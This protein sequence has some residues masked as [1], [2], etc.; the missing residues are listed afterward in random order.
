MRKGVVIGETSKIKNKRRLVRLNGKQGFF[1]ANDS[2]NRPSFS[3]G[4]LNSMKPISLGSIT[5]CPLIRQ[6]PAQVLV[7]LFDY[8]LKV[9]PKTG[10]L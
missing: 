5:R 7:N 3:S 8:Q 4:F 1:K 2:R 6:R 10:P 9:I